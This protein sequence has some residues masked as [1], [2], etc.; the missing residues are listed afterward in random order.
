LKGNG[1]S[2]EFKTFLIEMLWTYNE[3][4]FSVQQDLILFLDNASSH[5]SKEVVELYGILG[6]DVIFN[7]PFSPEHA[8]VEMYFAALKA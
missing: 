7:S 4:G 6:V 8:G 1:N 2:Q 5:W 3:A